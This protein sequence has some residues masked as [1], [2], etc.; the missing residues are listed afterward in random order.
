MAPASTRNRRDPTRTGA[1]V[2]LSPTR[3]VWNASASLIAV[4]SR[5]R[6][7]RARSLVVPARSSIPNG[8]SAARS[9]ALAAMPHNRRRDALPCCGG[10]DRAHHRRVRYSF[11]TPRARRTMS[12]DLKAFLLSVGG[13][14]AVAGSGLLMLWVLS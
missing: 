2:R 9:R 3:S 12:N 14:L 8:H 1:I 10:G 11:G 5:P 4:S 7:C 6:V 13:L